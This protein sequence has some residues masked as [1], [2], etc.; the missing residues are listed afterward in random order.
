MAS[1]SAE[2]VR[3]SLT[4][5]AILQAGLRLID[6]QGAQA[7]TMRRLAQELGVDPMSIYNHLENKD[8]LLDGLAE[9]LWEEVE[10]PEGDVGWEALL[11]SIATSLRHLAHV[12]PH[13]YALL[14][15]RCQ[16]LPLAMLQLYDVTLERLQR[17]GFERER[18]REIV[19]T[20]GSYALGYAMVE[21]SA[22]QPEQSD[23][24]AEETTDFGRITQVMRRLPRETP[25][26]LVEVACVMATCD[27]DA[28][29]AFG[30]D[31]MLTG[32]RSRQ[33]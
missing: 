14:L 2:S 32:L 26:R 4:R 3:R 11:R 10:L 29:F 5:E 22:L 17:A 6:Q 33:A 24:A 15:N 9:L 12:H 8:A 25:A 19:C 30:L 13:A 20:V 31:L 1:S 23:H 18:A 21:L 28:Q 27:T 16:S 7:L